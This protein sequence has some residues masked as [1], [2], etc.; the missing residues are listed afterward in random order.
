MRKYIRLPLNKKKTFIK[1]KLYEK[2]TY[3]FNVTFNVWHYAAWDDD[4]V[5]T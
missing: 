4:G 5:W 2:K 3:Y 1:E